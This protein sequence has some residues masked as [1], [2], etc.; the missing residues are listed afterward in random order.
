MTK[1]KQTNFQKE[2]IET[3]THIRTNFKNEKGE[4][5]AQHVITNPN[6]QRVSCFDLEVK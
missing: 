3:K 1:K 6:I 2:V 5:V 4:I